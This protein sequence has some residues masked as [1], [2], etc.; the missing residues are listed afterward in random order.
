MPG[1]TV[2]ALSGTTRISNS[3]KKIMG[4]IIYSPVANM[5]VGFEMGWF[6]RETIDQKNGQAVRTQVALTYKF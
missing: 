4:N 1:S 6:K 2:S 3:F 5:D